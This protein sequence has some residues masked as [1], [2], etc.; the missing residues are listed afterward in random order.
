M[1]LNT[2]NCKSKDILS[3]K[4]WGGIDE[5]ERTHIDQDSSNPCNLVEDTR[6]K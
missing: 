5:P 6:A 2:M 4:R 1:K 3:W